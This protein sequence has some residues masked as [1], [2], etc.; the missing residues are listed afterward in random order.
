[1]GLCLGPYGGPRGGAFSYERGTHVRDS[2]K[3]DF[4]LS[5]SLSHAHTHSLA[6]S[7]THTLLSFAGAGR[8]AHGGGR[9]ITCSDL[10]AILLQSQ[11]RQGKLT[12]DEM[13]VE[14]Q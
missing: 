9:S 8:G 12:C 4:S 3:G 14:H 6:L 13:F 1:M 5:L 7:L 11:L 2:L 10:Q